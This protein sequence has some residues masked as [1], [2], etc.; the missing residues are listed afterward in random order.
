[1][2]KVYCGAKKLPKNAVLGT[3]EQCKKQI[4]LYGL[5]PVPFGTSRRDVP[6]TITQPEP[7]TIKPTIGSK[8][9]PKTKRIRKVTTAKSAVKPLEH[10]K[11]DELSEPEEAIKRPSKIL[12]L[13][14]YLEYEEQILFGLNGSMNII[15][16]F[17]NKKNIIYDKSRVE[18]GYISVLYDNS[19][20]TYNNDI[21]AYKR[22]NKMWTTFVNID[23][24]DDITLYKRYVTDFNKIFKVHFEFLESSKIENYK[25]SLKTLHDIYNN[26]QQIVEK[27]KHK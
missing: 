7:A 18:I 24:K 3:Y 23:K 4:R 26:H 9:Q 21:T 22:Y 11:L 1:M 16:D 6:T 15:I 20:E 12:P 10:S 8:K 14:E 25:S 13:R 2:S 27:L 17:F 5:R 19:V